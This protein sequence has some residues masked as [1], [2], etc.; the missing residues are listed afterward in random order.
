MSQFKLQNPWPFRDKELIRLW[1][2]GLKTGAITEK[3]KL[4]RNS[5][6]GRVKRLRANGFDLTE[7]G[8][9]IK[10]DALKRGRRMTDKERLDA[11]RDRS[12]RR[13]EN[14]RVERR[15][16]GLPEDGTPGRKKSVASVT[17][18]YTPTEYVNVPAAPRPRVPEEPIPDAPTE[19]S[20]SFLDAADKSKCLW[21]YG[22][23]KSN[24]SVC[25]LDKVKGSRSYCAAHQ[26]KSTDRKPDS[27]ARI[28]YQVRPI[29]GV[30]M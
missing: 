6:L 19:G 12:R 25:G 5:I 1:N 14:R 18:E 21:P 23:L 28:N 9:P 7:R 26:A 22:D 16:L 29:T 17:D 15:A 8:D 2:S 13:T 11:E 24:G 10:V 30:M 3:M 27:G 20:M 4:S